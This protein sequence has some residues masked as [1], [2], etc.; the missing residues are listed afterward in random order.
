MKDKFSAKFYRAMRAIVRV[1]IWPFYRTKY[2]NKKKI[3]TEGRFVIASNHIS[4]T[5]PIVLGVG[6]KRII[7]YMGKADLF[8]SKFTNWLFSKLGAFPVERGK[9]DWDSINNAKKMIDDGYAIGIFIEGTRSQT[10]ELLK[11][12][13]GAVM[14]AH[15]MECQIVPVS[16][17][18]RTK[19]YHKFARRYVTFGEPVTTEE[20]GI[21]KGGP[22]E[23]RDAS[24]ALME[25]ISV[26]WK[27]DRYGNQNS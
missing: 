8:G 3:P 11:P 7:R 22:R 25:K 4:S 19:K 2:T 24:R 15:Q 27:K 1:I 5:D 17:T 10:G 16:I 12:K 26:M 9:G 18:Y 6:Q 20:L 23:Y 21:T 14:L 13:S